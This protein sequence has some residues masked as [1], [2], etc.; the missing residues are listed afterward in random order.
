MSE[1]AKHRRGFDV[2]R[3]PHEE[4]QWHDLLADDLSTSVPDQVAFKLDWASFL[5]AHSPRD[6]HIMQLLSFGHAA[7]WVANKHKLSPARV[8]QLRKQWQKQWRAFVGDSEGI[9]MTQPFEKSVP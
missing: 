5:N 6:R 2:R 1:S 9:L 7:K 4:Q 3:L 8:T